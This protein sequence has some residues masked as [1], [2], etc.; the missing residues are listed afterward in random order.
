MRKEPRTYNGED[1]VSWIIGS[2]KTWQFHIKNKMRTFPHTTQ[3][4]KL[5]TY[6]RPKCKIWNH[7]TAS[8]EHR[9]NAL[10][11]KL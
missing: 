5:R 11:H 4:N 6:K 8:R 7:K 1:T 9:Q 2:R 3:K 10:W